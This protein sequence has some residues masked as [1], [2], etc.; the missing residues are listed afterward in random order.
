MIISFWLPVAILVLMAL[1]F[2]LY[3]LAFGRPENRA[4]AE[5]RNQNLLAYRTRMAELDAERD[6][7]LIEE[8]HYQQLRDELAGSMLD[9]VGSTTTEGE[10]S[11]DELVADR[12][13]TSTWVVVIVA[14]VLIPA[15]AV[16]AYLEWGALHRVEQ[17]Q[18]M[19]EIEASGDGR[20]LQMEDLTRQLHDRLQAQ[21]DNPDGWAMLGRSYMQMERYE[22]AAKVFE[23]LAGVVD[24]RPSRAVAWGLSAQA[25]FF[26]TQGR[27]DERVTA[28]IEQARALNE[29]EVNSLGLL[30]IYAFEQRRFEEAIG[31]W[32]RILEV[33]P[34]H[35]QI[36]AIRRGVDQAYQHL[37][38][39][40]PERAEAA[41]VSPRGV[42]VRVELDEAFE[43]QVAPD[44]TLFVYARTP[45]LQS[46]PL[47]VARLRAAELPVTLRLDDRLAMAPEF[48]ISGAGEVILAARLT[49]SGA[50]MP[51]PGDWQGILGEPVPVSADEEQTPVLLVIDQQLH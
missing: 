15:G 39:P 40:A 9:D 6:Q 41:P 8:E 34:D 2:V 37:G 44:T 49:V 50:A 38:V 26:V 36:T 47:A 31:Y 27:M 51:Q 12:R 28:A 42:N 3:P 18:A 20:R 7:G 24:D 25:W 4:A 16:F 10:L 33:A 48:Q 17:F 43:G 13:R 35:P 1:A 22:D 21:P 29:D 32:E 11:S 23:R 46:A 14:F 19:M 5:V 30:G 45:D